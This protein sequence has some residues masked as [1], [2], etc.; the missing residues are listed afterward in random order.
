[1]GELCPLHCLGCET[2]ILKTVALPWNAVPLIYQTHVNLEHIIAT[3]KTH[4]HK[5]STMIAIHTGN[6]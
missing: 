4:M 5:H 6:K 3:F 2:Y 1:M